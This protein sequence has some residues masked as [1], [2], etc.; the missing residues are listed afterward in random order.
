MA[1]TSHTTPGENSTLR[2]QAYDFYPGG[3]DLHWTR[4]GEV[5]ESES[6]GDVLPSGGGTYLSSVVLE[7]PAQDRELYS[8]HV[9]H[10]ALAQPLSVPWKGRQDAGAGGSGGTQSQ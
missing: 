8:C 9:E 6:G 5:Q 10:S 7:V 3:I 2:C 4:D 1:V